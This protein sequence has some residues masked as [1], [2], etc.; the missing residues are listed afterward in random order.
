MP[1]H[2]H[3]DCNLCP[4]INHLPDVIIRYDRQGRRL[5]VNQ[6]YLD[7]SGL[8]R[9]Q[10][11]GKK[12]DECWPGW[13]NETVASQI[14]QNMEKVFHDKTPT[15]WHFHFTDQGGFQH[16]HE[17]SA[18]PEYDEHGNVGTALVIARDVSPTRNVHGRLA[19]F[20]F[21]LDHVHE[22]F[23]LLDEQAH[24]LQVNGEACRSLGYSR[25]ELLGMTVFDIDPE[26]S[27]Q[28]WLTT[29]ENLRVQKH[30]TFEARHHTK[31]GQLI[32]V[33]VQSNFLVFQGQIYYLALVRDISDVKA[34]QLRFD[35]VEAQAHIGHWEWDFRTKR[36]LL[37]AEACRIFGEPEGWRPNMAETL[38]RMIDEDRERVVR[39]VRQA[40]FERT[41]ETA[42]SYRI[43]RTGGG[44]RYLHSNVL[45][46]YE[47]TSGKPLRLV[48]TTQDVT[49][50]K[51][52]EHYI[53][54][55]TFSDTLTGLPNR[56]QLCQ[57]A[58]QAIVDAEWNGRQLG[59][60]L[61]DLDRFKEINETFGHDAG[62]QLLI[63]VAERLSNAVRN[64]DILA[65]LGADE[66]AVILPAIRHGSDLEAITRKIFD[67][68]TAPFHHGDRDI[69]LATSL[70][71]A[72]FPQDA[73][74]VSS[75][76]QYADAAL[77][78]AKA[79]GRSCHRAYSPQ[80]T[81]KSQKRL[82]LENALR[83]A[84]PHQELALYYQP[85]VDLTEQRIVGAEALIRWNNPQLGFIPPNLF[86]PI[87]EETGLILPIGDWVLTTA[88]RQAATWNSA[89]AVPL[90]I[91]VNLSTRQFRSQHLAERIIAIA[92]QTGCH[93]SWIELEIT[94][95]LLL[96]DS[97]GVLAALER[98]TAAG[99]S[100]AIDDFGTGYS[101]LSYLHRFPIQTL[102]ID[103]SFVSGIMNA[104][105]SAELVKA[106]L[107]M[108]QALHLSVVAEGVEQAGEE[109]FLRANGSQ[110]GQGY[111]WGKPMPAPEFQ[112]ILDALQT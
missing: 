104:P 91:A 2:Q 40:L 52:R 15:S 26:F 92:E 49:E 65:R 94:E 99:F 80:L 9:E 109:Q 4:T 28:D 39:I 18:V 51:T 112:Q 77:G 75:L 62:D 74:D 86:I 19:L 25:A 71:T 64:Y 68:F 89:R 93:P 23:F 98:L 44:V 66:F 97:A 83:Q 29:S 76:L 56:I 27:W 45:I 43:I 87:A 105:N 102:K 47:A 21:A 60:M 54:D 35:L 55:L 7:S 36:S 33:E 46:E 96:D 17:M 73:G 61:I 110:F 95:S 12:L 100:I 84:I 41:A 69:Y 59:L 31:D 5:L 72:F 13:I 85:Q 32:A 24:I 37:S 67:C 20:E 63:Q 58:H 90:R 22:S 82:Q 42:Y 1:S 78:Q 111:L 16:F 48:A 10:V 38:A 107:S 103:R 8:T 79:H 81:A 101:A 3:H 70:G 88:F 30:I 34:N 6:Q 53:H 57:C 50:I 11:L 14:L 106:I 108:A